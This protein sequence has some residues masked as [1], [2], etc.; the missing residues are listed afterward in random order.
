MA[1][2]L[3]VDDTPGLLNMMV[4]ALDMPEDEIVTARNLDHALKALREQRF[5][6][7]VTDLA[8][9]EETSRPEV[10]VSEGEGYKIL[11]TAKAE[12]SECRVIVITSYDE[13]AIG[14]RAMAMGAYDYIDRSE[15]GGRW[16]GRL[17]ECVNAVV[18]ELRQE[19]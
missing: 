8:L 14:P 13:P 5:D 15:P 1:R 18:E 10:A 7:V 11:E 16:P 12:N 3:L 6:V 4:K 2:I 19:G 17:R 9:S